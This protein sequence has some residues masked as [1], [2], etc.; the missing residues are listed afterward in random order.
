MKRIAVISSSVRTGRL[1]HRVA[2]FIRN[3]F[4]KNFSID[5]DLLDLKQYDFPLFE[6]RLAFQKNLSEPLRDFTRRFLQADGIFVVSPVYNASFPASLKNVIDLYNLEWT[7]KVVGIASVSSGGTAGISTVEQLGALFLK[8]GAVVSPAFY[9]AVHVA[10]EFD[11]GG[12]PVDV[13]K[14]EEFF[15]P[16]AERFWSL[17]DKLS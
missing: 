14:A 2:I 3:Y 4:E 16:V 12:V 10:E 8:L 7:S 6:E 1:S 11:A 9:T 13:Q 15:R 17:I 5:A